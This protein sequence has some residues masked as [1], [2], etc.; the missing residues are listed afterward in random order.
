MG[1]DH[2][3]LGALMR[4]WAETGVACVG[5]DA[6]FHGERVIRMPDPSSL[7]RQPEEGLAFVVQTVVDNRRV[8][9]WLQTRPDLD[10]SRV[11]YAGFSMGSILG[12][13][14]VAVEPRIRIAAFALGGAGMM[15]FFAGMAPP[16][17]RARFDR[18]AD[19][20]DPLHF[21]PLIAPRPVLMVNGLRD[22]V[23]PAATGHV[24][25]NALKAPKRI[26][27][28]DGDHASIPRE[29]LHEMR[30]FLEG[31]LAA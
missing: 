26:L 19:A 23:V 7:L 15:H 14:F 27:W 17:M 29:H 11:A 3:L 21:A 10:A 6:P 2:M 1:K 13:P 25:F 16:A 31:G 20:V 4:A 18:L 22:S 9:D 8:L 30:I 28:Y 12:V 5:V 24:L